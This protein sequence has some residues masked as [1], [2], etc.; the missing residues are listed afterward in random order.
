MLGKGYQDGPTNEE[1]LLDIVD[2]LISTSAFYDEDGRKN[3][4]KF[5][6]LVLKCVITLDE[7][8]FEHRSFLDNEKIRDLYT[9]ILSRMRK[10][11]DHIFFGKDYM[12]NV[13]TRLHDS[14]NSFVG[15]VT[16]SYR[17]CD[18]NI[19]VVISTSRYFCELFELLSSD[20]AVRR[21]M[22][23]SNLKPSI[24]LSFYLIKQIMI[25]HK[26]R[27]NIGVVHFGPLADLIKLLLGVLSAPGTPERSSY[28]TT[29]VCNSIVYEPHELLKDSLYLHTRYDRE[30]LS[31]L[32]LDLYCSVFV[33]Q[34]FGL[35]NLTLHL[36]EASFYTQCSHIPTYLY[37]ANMY[38][39]SKLFSS[40]GRSFFENHSGTR[41]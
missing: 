4:E 19:E 36:K 27:H 24:A 6:N 12:S 8:I 38:I 1:S 3:S 32:M 13:T 15:N 17:N 30:D 7:M 9:I 22:F 33:T 5:Q 2:C 35:D 20:I 10:V 34:G 37:K 41:W 14:Y 11:D 40:V 29:P 26:E 31:E 25:Y 18:A 16:R 39:Y 28:S 21:I 23:R